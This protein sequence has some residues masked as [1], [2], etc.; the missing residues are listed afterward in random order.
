[1][2]DITNEIQQLNIDS[3]TLGYRKK[4][5]LNFRDVVELYS[6]AKQLSHQLKFILKFHFNVKN[7]LNRKQNS[8]FPYLQICLWFQ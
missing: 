4:I 6:D 5:K 8:N 2:K 1:M 3:D 7:S